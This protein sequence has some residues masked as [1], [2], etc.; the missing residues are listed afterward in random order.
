MSEAA[1]L[2]GYGA[3]ARLVIDVLAASDGVRI[4]HVLVRE[5][6]RGEVARPAG[7]GPVPIA[8]LEELD[9][10]PRLVVECAGHQAVAQFG[11]AVLSR[12]L[13]L[14]IVSIGALADPAVERALADAAHTGGAR[15]HLLPGAIGGI[16]ALAA[17]AIAGLDTVSYISRKPPAAWCGTPAELLFDLPGIG[18]PT[19]LYE[20]SAREA[21]RLYPKNANIAATVALAGLGFERTKVRLV[22]DPAAEGNVHRIEAAGRCGQF[23]IELSGRPLPDNPKTSMLTV[24][25]VVRAIRNLTGTVAL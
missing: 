17:A 1:A 23:T 12:G 25:S 3:V 16:D 24:Y 5:G 19:T 20:G 8:S 13:D 9:V 2:I 11:P 18:R 22:A 15:L 7:N 6:R 10:R 14:A 21:A 4:S